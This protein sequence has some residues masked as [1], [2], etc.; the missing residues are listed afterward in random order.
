[1]LVADKI[2]IN[3]NSTFATNGSPFDGI[4][5]SVSPASTSLNANQTQQFTA[6]VA[7]SGNSAVTWSVTPSVG[8]ISSSGLVY[9]PGNDHVTSQ[10][11]VTVKATSQED[12]SKNGTATITL[13]PPVSVAVS[14]ATA[15]LY[16]GQTQQLTAVVANNPN[17]A[18]VW[19]LSPAVGT[20]TA[21]GLYTAPA[22]VITAQTVTATAT[23]VAD[24]TKSASAVLTLSPP[25]T[26]S[27]SPTTA[28]LYASHAQQF[29]ATV[30]NTTNH[31][32]YVV[33]CSSGRWD[34][35]DG[36]A[37]HGAQQHRHPAN[38]NRDGDECGE[39]FRFRFG[40]DYAGAA[41]G[42][43]RRES[44]FGGALRRPGTGLFGDRH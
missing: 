40:D 17:T 41:G 35:H 5:V 14:P 22:S 19:S 6:T 12:S 25:V 18:V 44:E 36:R 33:D 30:T 20:I 21:S 28:T 24:P 26:V 2:Y 9:G 34:D 16:Q 42:S 29:T 39:H 37:L 3:G 38:G 43:D 7:N 32:R 8:T 1:M 31:W 23:S 27:V 13:Y 15:T 11:T 4:T 10:Q